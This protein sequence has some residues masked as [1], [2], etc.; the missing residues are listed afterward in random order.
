[1]G[2]M[3]GNQTKKSWMKNHNV[4][5]RQNYL[6][7]KIIAVLLEWFGSHLTLSLTKQCKIQTDWHFHKQF[8]NVYMAILAKQFFMNKFFLKGRLFIC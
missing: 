8:L 5:Y 7:N 3:N 4:K 6:N 1:M 2:K